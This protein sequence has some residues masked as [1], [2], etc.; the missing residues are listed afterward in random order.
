MSAN[1]FV[2]KSN[3][4]IGAAAAEQDEQYLSECFVDTGT[5]SIL[6]DCQDHRCLLV[7]R[8]GSGKSALIAQIREEGEHVIAIQP[9]LLSLAYISNSAVI[10][11]FSEAGV[12]L[13]IF[14][15]LL[16]RHVFV[17][18][19]LKERFGIDSEKQKQNF[20][21][22]IWN[23]I[24]R[25]RK[26]EMA[27][28][29]LKD[30]GDSFW[31]ETD[32]RVKEVTSKLEKDL[33]GAMEIAVPD[34]GKLNFS[35]AKKLTKEQKEEVIHRGQEVVSK[36]QIKELTA[37]IDLLDEVLLVDRKKRYYIAIDKLDEDWV[38]D[39][40]RFRLI[41][42]LIETSLEFTRI[43][44]VKV[45][46]ALRNDLLDRVYRFTRD[47]GF[48]EEKYRTSSLDLTWTKA[49]LIEVLDRRIDKLVKSQ[50]TNQKVTHRE[51]LR[52][53]PL[54]NKRKINAIDYMIDRTLLRPRD[55]IQF[56]NICIAQ[57]DG[58][59]IVDAHT[60]II[61]EGIYSRERFR[62]LVDE[63]LGVYPNLALSAKILKRRRPNFEIRDLSVSDIEE[64]CLQSAT[65]PD[66]LE[67]DD[68]R[69]MQMVME[70]GIKPEEYR[71]NLI[72][73]FYKVGLVGLRT[74]DTLPVS[75]T[76]LGSPSVSGAEIED[77][78]RIYV[79]PTFWRHFGITNQ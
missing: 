17:V 49:K 42:S 63:W 76:Y 1:Q 46:I 59:A 43:A 77:D 7:G 18:E 65:S 16:W 66:A 72:L 23:T 41:R 29:Y 38:E 60:V 11:F 2:F 35:S 67:G 28:D 34:L 48:Q 78:S 31:H 73:M 14:Y 13:N 51:L 45:I 53:I 40:L 68:L 75:W 24:T 8:T 74:N 10:K 55:L 3:Q 70:D 69:E 58:K 9:D 30:W 50:Y 21:I 12:N 52:D 27:L 4:T 44:N 32:Q 15:R 5:L 25:N 20:F 47:T 26:N 54:K 22:N 56:F 71:K 19:I 57:S 62:A 79:Q 37:I 64:N 39:K 6:L 33:Q 36:V 61:A